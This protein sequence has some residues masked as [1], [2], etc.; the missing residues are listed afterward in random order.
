MLT[1]TT[2]ALAHKS[3]AWDKLHT[4]AHTSM[5]SPFEMITLI[6]H[7]GGKIRALSFKYDKVILCRGK[8][9]SEVKGQVKVQLRMI[10]II[11]FF[12]SLMD[13]QERKTY[14]TTQNEFM[15]VCIVS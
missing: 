11:R 7:L 8:V 2:G 14:Y 9:V 5:N 3:C 1:R 10:K 12:F 4:R 13:T 6:K 15:K